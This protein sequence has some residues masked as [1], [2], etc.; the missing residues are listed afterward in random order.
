VKINISSLD[1]TQ[2]VENLRRE[3]AGLQEK[4]SLLADEIRRIVESKL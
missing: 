3:I 1:D 2:F 4:S